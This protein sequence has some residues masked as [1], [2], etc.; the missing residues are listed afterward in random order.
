[1]K[2]LPESSS[3]GLLRKLLWGPGMTQGSG[4]FEGLRQP[5]FH[6]DPTSQRARDCSPPAR[7]HSP[8]LHPWRRRTSLHLSMTKKMVWVPTLQ[9]SGKYW[10]TLRALKITCGTS[11]SRRGS[12]WSWSVWRY[13]EWIN[14]RR[15]EY[16]NFDYL[17]HHKYLSLNECP[18]M[19]SPVPAGH[20]DALR[21]GTF[22]WGPSQGS[23]GGSHGGG[24]LLEVGWVTHGGSALEMFVLPSG[25][26]EESIT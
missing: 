12:L 17:L 3:L 11:G 1:M 2:D 13:W 9:E 10:P 14:Y 6:Q 25:E 26:T 4:I 16:K 21:L 8:D 18:H 7:L 22:F 5:D 19:N 23:T 24:G 15:G 20:S